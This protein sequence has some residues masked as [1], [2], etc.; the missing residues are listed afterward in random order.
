MQDK[1]ARQQYKDVKD[2]AINARKQ[3]LQVRASCFGQIS[4]RLLSRQC[5]PSLN[6]ALYMQCL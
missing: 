6:R 3:K 1:A 5:F 4:A 2:A